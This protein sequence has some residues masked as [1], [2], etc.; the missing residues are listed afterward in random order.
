MNAAVAM[1]LQ[2]AADAEE[3]RGDDWRDEEEGPPEPNGEERRLCVELARDRLKLAKVFRFGTK[4]CA[5]ET[6]N[7]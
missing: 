1:I 4:Q 6:R 5:G 2:M 3:K 7:E